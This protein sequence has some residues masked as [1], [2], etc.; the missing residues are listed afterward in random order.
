MERCPHADDNARVVFIGNRGFLLCDQCW[1]MAMKDRQTI[2]PE[3]AI[4]RL[5]NKWGAL[6]E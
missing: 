6:T 4:Q 2:L 3:H 1:E 5:L